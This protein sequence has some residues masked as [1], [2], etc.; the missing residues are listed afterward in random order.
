MSIQKTKAGTWRVNVICGRDSDGKYQRITKTVKSKYEAQQLEHKLIQ[1]YHV[2][3]EALERITLSDFTKGFY[4][5]SKK[6]K[7]RYQSYRRYSTDINKRIL[8]ELG[9]MYLDEIGHAHVQR[10]ID[11]CPTF[12][13]AQTARAT[14][15]AILHL[16]FDMG[17]VNRNV[18][19]QTYDLPQ[20]EI[21]PEQHNGTWLTT[22]EQHIE[23]IDKIDQ[24]T[25]KTMCVLGLCFGLRKGEIFGLDWEDVD[26]ERHTI[27]VRKTYVK[28]EGG[29]KLMSPKTH[30]SDRYIPIMRHAEEYLIDIY[31]SRDSHTGAVLINRYGVR[32]SPTKLARKWMIYLDKNNLEEV[33]ILNMRHSFA[34]A[35]LN[36]GVDVTKV[37]KM[38]GHT[39]ITTTTNR[40]LRFKIDDLAAELRSLD[41]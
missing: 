17:Y 1:K 20:R 15:R 30:E 28:E 2:E 13:T 27:H 3:G 14:L 32:A 12:K 37:S 39:N 38:L 16:A 10:L 9:G 4:L 33:T 22:F 35:C 34:T 23:F 21:Y 8:P 26:F 29:H 5:P 24:P 25:F 19:Q 6:G 11:R 18:A 7:I 31:N 36:A 41:I 40:Y